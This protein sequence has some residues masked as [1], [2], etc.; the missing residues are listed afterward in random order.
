[1]CVYSVGTHHRVAL[2]L[3]ISGRGGGLV[4]IYKCDFLMSIRMFLA[5]LTLM[6]KKKERKRNNYRE[7]LLRLYGGFAFVNITVSVAEN[8]NFVINKI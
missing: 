4:G 7:I 1:M 5:F 6:F 8:N 2:I 3:P